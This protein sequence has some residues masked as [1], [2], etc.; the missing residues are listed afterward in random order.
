[1][2]VFAQRF[3]AAP[4]APV[5]FHRVPFD[6]LRPRWINQL[7]FAICSWWQTRRGFDL[8]HSHESTWHGQVQT[9]HVRPVK[10]GLF[11]A[12]RVLIRPRRWF[13]IATSPR[14]WVYLAL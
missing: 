8:V 6:G 2:H 14:L 4:A 11:T 5:T 10:V 13:T 3:G 12:Q 7:W 9:V 1:I